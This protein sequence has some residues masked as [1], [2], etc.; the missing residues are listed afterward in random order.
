MRPQLSIDSDNNIKARCNFQ[1]EHKDNTID[2]N[3]ADSQF[4]NGYS[5]EGLRVGLKNRTFELLYDIGAEA[6]TFSLKSAV[7]VRDK[8][9]NVKYVH[10]VKKN[11]A[12]L[13]TTMQVDDNNIA[14]LNYDLSNFDKFDHKAIVFKWSYRRDDIT[15]EPSFN[16]AN[17][18]LACTAWYTVD[19]DNKLKA[20]YD[21]HTQHGW[22]QWVNNGALGG[23]GELKVTARANLENKDS[24]KQMP[25]ILVEKT[26]TI[27]N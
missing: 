9:I 22:V 23:G 19:D 20:H 6:P 1:F 26:W 11:A 8:T 3:V 2:I 21:L 15:V 4:K 12:H 5:N 16:M 7:N 27:D 14:K 24:A 13:E 18:S 10:A 25:T 17:E